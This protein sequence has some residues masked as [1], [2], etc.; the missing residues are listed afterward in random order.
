MFNFL[1]SSIV[2]AFRRPAK[3]NLIVYHIK[4]IGVDSLSVVALS[5]FSPAWSWASRVTTACANSAP[6]VFSVPPPPSV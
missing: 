6:K 1:L 3:L 2:L 4:T 5:G